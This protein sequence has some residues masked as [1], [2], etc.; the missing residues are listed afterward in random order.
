MSEEKTPIDEVET[1][2]IPT[3]EVTPDAPAEEL[4]D[5][6]LEKVSGGRALF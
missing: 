2:A 1:S 6:D 3:S 4:T 5:A